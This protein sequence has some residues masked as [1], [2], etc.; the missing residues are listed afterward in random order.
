MY[1]KGIAPAK[2][3]ICCASK[4]I[5]V[6]WCFIINFGC[7]PQKA[8]MAVRLTHNN[9]QYSHSESSFC[10]FRHNSLLQKYF[11][12]FRAYRIVLI[13]LRTNKT[14]MEIRTK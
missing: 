14:A 8:D 2:T 5:R 11:T 10:L 7:F 4:T 3:G 12:G 9:Q 13:A 1:K 6:V